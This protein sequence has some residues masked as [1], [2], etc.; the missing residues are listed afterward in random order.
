[1]FKNIFVILKVVDFFLGGGGGGIN[2]LH[3]IFYEQFYKNMRLIFDLRTM[4]A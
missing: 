4:P 1:M 2:Q 3:F